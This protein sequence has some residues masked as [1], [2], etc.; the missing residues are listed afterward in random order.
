LLLIHYLFLF[1]SPDQQKNDAG[2]PAGWRAGSTTTTCG[3]TA[4]QPTLPFPL[5]GDWAACAAKGAARHW[6]DT[7]MKGMGRFGRKRRTKQKKANT[8]LPFQTIFKF[9]L[10]RF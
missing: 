7:A 6:L 9:A 10:K 2:T 1:F 3:A 4:G 8:L 5:H